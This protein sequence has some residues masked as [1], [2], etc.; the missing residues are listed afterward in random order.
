MNNP[1]ERHNN[2]HFLAIADMATP[3]SASPQTLA[4][5][6]PQR[7]QHNSIYTPRGLFNQVTLPN[8]SHLQPSLAKRRTKADQRLLSEFG[9]SKNTP[10]RRSSHNAMGKRM[11]FLLSGHHHMQKVVP[12]SY[13]HALQLDKKA[14]L[15]SQYRLP[16]FR[17]GF[18][19]WIQDTSLMDPMQSEITVDRLSRGQENSGL[20]LPSIVTLLK[21][22]WY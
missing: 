17:E 16:S 21:R 14:L 13:E 3:T 2:V 8:P 7:T 10:M 11:F 5:S 6:A 9:L 22:E 20:H 15:V 1:Q 19:D 18:S 4:D 12:P